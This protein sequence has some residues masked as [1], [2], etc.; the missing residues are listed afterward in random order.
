MASRAAPRRSGAKPGN[1]LVREAHEPRVVYRTDWGEMIEASA[2][3]ALTSRLVDEHRG[4]VQL[5]L[6]S[7]PFP[8][9]KKKR[10]GNLQGDA[11][12][13]WLAQAAPLLRKMLTPDGSVVIELG[14]AWEPGRPVMST[15][16]LRSLLGFQEAGEFALCQQF[17]A[18]NPARLPSPAQWV[19][20]ER[21]RVKDAYTNIWWMAPTDRPKADNRRVLVPYSGRMKELLAAGKYNAGRRPSEYTIGQT[22][23]LT[24]HGGAIPS[25]LLRFS[26]TA[27]IDPYQDFCREHG[28][29]PH[30]ARMARGIAE[31]FIDFL[32]DPKDLVLDPFAGSNTTGAVAEALGRRWLAIEPRREYILGS[33]GRFPNHRHILQV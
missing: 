17:I 33:Q 19:T 11:Y 32:T 18:Y 29:Q 1:G 15:L 14:N 13:E 31:F 22:S 24:D 21:I 7:P 3:R 20:V 16:G 12:A 9:N 6:T 30:P 25:N 5:V 8:L 4:K 26:N 10:Y 2:E 27:S 23:F 28:F